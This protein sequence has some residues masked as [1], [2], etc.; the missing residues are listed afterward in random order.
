MMN[1]IKRLFRIFALVTLLTLM[2]VSPAKGDSP[3]DSAYITGVSGHAQGYSLSCESRSAVDLAAFWGISI[4]ETEFLQSLPHADNPD[5]GFV[6]DPN[7]AWGNLPPHGYG[8]HAGPV[9]ETLQEFGLEAE[10]YHD[11]S[12][13]DLRE[14]IDAGRPVIVWVIGQMWD[15]TPVEYEAPDGSTTTVAAFEHTMILTGYSTD[16]VQ[17]VDAYS[18]QYQAYW[19]KTF[20]KSWAVL[21]N[22]AVFGTHE[23]S[24][25]DDSAI[26]ETHG[27]SYTVQYGDYLVALADR[28]GTTWQELAQL[29]LIGYP[30]TI[31]PGQVLQLPEGEAQEVQAEAPPETEPEPVESPPTINSG[32]YQMH[33]PMVQR[34]SV[35]LSTSPVVIAPI[36]PEPAE[37]VIV[38]SSTM[39]VIF[40]KS[41]GVDW[42]LLAELNDLHHPYLV[43]TGQ[44][45]QLR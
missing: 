33:L 40:C 34:N 5:Q 3:P 42:H 37:T 32:N 26:S 25:N 2:H 15:G 22:M 10:A 44:V 12:W 16:V 39:L 28:F 4:G 21:G 9:A 1:P 17:V 36:L 13:D 14:E 19:L 30:F 6:G 35:V 20:L 41:I 11:I 29:N 18:G 7:D 27:D 8:V 45:L 24:S 43:H 31:F 38:P 23:V